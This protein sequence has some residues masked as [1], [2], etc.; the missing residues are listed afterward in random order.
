MRVLVVEDSKSLRQSLRLA[1]RK[2]GYAVDV[3]EE[4]ETGLWLAESNPYDV[5]ILDLML[6]KVDGLTILHRLR[7]QG[8]ETPVLIL[9]A[10][11][12]INDR[13]K[14]L[15]TGADDYLTKPFALEELL[16]RVEALLRR[17][18]NARNPRLRVGDLVMDTANRTLEQGGR[19]IELTPR[20]YAL[21]EF[22]ASRPGDVVTRTEIEEHLYDENTELFSNTI[23]SA[24][25]TLR[26]KL[27]APDQKAIIRTRKGMGYVL[28]VRP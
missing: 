4:G 27:A 13:V 14:G 18:R 17:K 16:A 28:E 19:R 5:I 24:I 12:A 8:R 7:D 1:L 15:R 20:E 21:L 2:A 9:T 10:L 22:L 3:A 6:P 25:C 23:D 11:D 26:K